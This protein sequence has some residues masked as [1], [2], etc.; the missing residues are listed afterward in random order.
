MPKATLRVTGK[1]EEIQGEVTI[2]AINLTQETG[3]D[4]E[5]WITAKSDEVFEVTSNGL[6]IDAQYNYILFDH[7]DNIVYAVQSIDLEFILDV[8]ST[9]PEP[10][11]TQTYY[12]EPQVKFLETQ[13]YRAIFVEKGYF[14]QE[15][16]ATSFEDAERQAKEMHP[17]P[18]DYEVEYSSEAE[19]DELQGPIDASGDFQV[20]RRF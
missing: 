2:S 5:T 20:S 10:K 13:I 8:S 19:L 15:I 3:K 9:L 7:R 4:L 1:V 18:T 16:E 17:H 12:E 11:P 6:M 14:T